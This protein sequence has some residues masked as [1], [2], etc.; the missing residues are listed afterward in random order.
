MCNSTC[1]RCKNLASIKNMI[2]LQHMKIQV[3]VQNSM[4]SMEHEFK[5]KVLWSKLVENMSRYTL[6]FIV[7]EI[8]RVERYNMNKSKLIA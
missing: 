1:D 6:H 3:P 7:E 8:D 2:K 4:I 5:G